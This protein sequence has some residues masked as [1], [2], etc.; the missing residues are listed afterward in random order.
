M[1]GPRQRSRRPVRRRTPHPSRDG[2]TSDSGEAEDRGLQ[3]FSTPSQLSAPRE[4]LAA[5]ASPGALDE[6]TIE[7]AVGSDSTG[8]ATPLPEPVTLAA[9][10]CAVETDRRQPGSLLRGPAETLES[11]AQVYWPLLIQPTPQPGHVAIFDGTGVWKRTFHHSV[12]P[13]V[14]R[15]KELLTPDLN[16]VELVSRLRALLPFLGQQTAA[17]SLDVEGFLPVDPPLLFE[18][19]SDSNLQGEPRSPH[20]GFLP[21]RHPVRW[22]ES[23]VEGMASS[24]DRFEAELRELD[25]VRLDVRAVVGAGLARLEGERRR[26]EGELQRRTQTAHA[27]MLR[28]TE[29]LHASTRQQIRTELDQIRA[30]NAIIS[31]A[32]VTTATSE[33]LASRAAQRGLD[34]SEHRSRAKDLGGREREARRQ[35]RDAQRRIEILHAQERQGLQVLSERVALVDRR[36]SEEISATDLLRDE[37]NAAGTDLVDA[38]GSQVS[39]RTAQRNLL[40]SYFLPLPTLTEVRIL[41]FPLWVATLRSG[42]GVRYL[43]FPPMRSRAGSD[44]STSVKGMFGGV[45]LPLEPRAASFDSA[46]RETM[47]SALATDAWFSHAMYEIVRAADAT[48]DSD[49]LLRLGQGLAELKQHGWVSDKQ[50]RKIFQAFSDHVQGRLSSGYVRPGQ[51]TNG[52]ETPQSSR[53]YW[54]T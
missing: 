15:L 33:V 39:A 48:M 31:H 54:A 10:L 14:S 3:G 12:L 50:A 44:L 43:V 52:G 17:E 21:A 37:L 9:I 7:F 24:L 19:L 8:K 29:A 23:T 36:A 32:Q 46:L 11:V 26:L 13:P 51:S 47:Q 30:S 41:W 20:A 2:E 16:S 34:D 45:A 5:R 49:F 53:P 28:D 6:V 1:A 22:Y 27:E 42:T 25:R 35:I 38:L 40:A 4:R 18:I